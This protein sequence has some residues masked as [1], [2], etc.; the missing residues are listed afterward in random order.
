MAKTYDSK[1]LDL[2]RHFDAGGASTDLA[3][4]IQDAIEDWFFDRDRAAE[5]GLSSTEQKAQGA[6]CGCRGADDYCVCQN[7][8]DATTRAERKV[9]RNPDPA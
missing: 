3:Q 1:C 8:T 2:A 7:V 4:T 5:P 9:V 6:R